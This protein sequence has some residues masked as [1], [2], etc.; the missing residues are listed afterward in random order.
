MQL[1]VDLLWDALRDTGVS[2]LGFYVHEGGDELVLGPLRD[3]PA[4]SPI[5]LHGACGQTLL[6]RRPLV[7]RDVRELGGG[8][9]ACDPRDRSEVVIPLFESDGR[10]W[11]VLDLDSHD[12][13][14]FSD[15]DVVGLERIVRAAGLSD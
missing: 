5:G 8:Y 10:C 3:K 7:V 11:G 9:I 12:V 14:S 6:S 15:A 13:E 4:C 1:V 2:W